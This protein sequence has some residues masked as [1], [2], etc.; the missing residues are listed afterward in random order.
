MAIINC[1]GQFGEGTG[2]DEVVEML[3]VLIVKVL[4]FQAHVKLW[5]EAGWLDIRLVDQ[6][7]IT[8]SERL[9]L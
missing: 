4:L 9:T 8:S 3:G 6:K 7:S 2:G 5:V 1:S